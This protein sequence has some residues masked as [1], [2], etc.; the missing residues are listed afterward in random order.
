[1]DSNI[2]STI[3]EVASSALETFKAIFSP[4]TYN[5]SENSSNTE[6]QRLIDLENTLNEARTDLTVRSSYRRH[7]TYQGLSRNPLVFRKD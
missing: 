7:F 6:S 2:Y 4:L 5:V 1:M 3:S